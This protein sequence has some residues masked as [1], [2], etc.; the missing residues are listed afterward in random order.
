MLTINANIILYSSLFPLNVSHV[1]SLYNIKKPNISSDL[2]MFSCWHALY[3]CTH[4]HTGYEQTRNTHTHTSIHTN[5]DSLIDLWRGSK[6]ICSIPLSD[7]DNDTNL[8]L[9]V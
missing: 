7:G 8:L 1:L 5:T 2:I 4:T 3:M 6:N 9:C